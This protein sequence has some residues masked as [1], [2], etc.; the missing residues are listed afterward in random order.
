VKECSVL[1]FPSGVTPVWRRK[2]G[3]TKP[4]CW[5][6]CRKQRAIT[7]RKILWG[8][9]GLNREQNGPSKNGKYLYQKVG[10][11]GSRY[12]SYAKSLLVWRGST[13]P[14]NKNKKGGEVIN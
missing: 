6:Q 11:L 2:G 14:I 3:R 9:G 10:G 7:V 1:E 8:K 5:P 13:S 4:D 12:E